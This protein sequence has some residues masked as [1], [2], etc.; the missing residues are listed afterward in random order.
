MSRRIISFFSDLHPG[1]TERLYRYPGQQGRPPLSGAHTNE[2]PLYYL[3]TTFAPVDEILYLRTRQV[4]EDKV[5]CGREG[6]LTAEEYLQK[7]V[8]RFC[9]DRG[10]PQPQMT[11]LDY[12]PANPDMEQALRALLTGIQPRDRIYLDVTGGPRNVS[13][14]MLL[15]TPCSVL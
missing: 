1:L 5:D 12:D 10:L 2:A 3:L 14:L 15:L 4:R 7:R 13:F 6:S 8:A 9:Q 11:P